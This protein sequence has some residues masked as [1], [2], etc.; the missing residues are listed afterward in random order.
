MKYVVQMEYFY[1]RHYKN[2]IIIIKSLCVVHHLFC[3]ST[4]IRTSF[5]TCSE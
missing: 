4:L 2:K 5:Q 1:N 3:T